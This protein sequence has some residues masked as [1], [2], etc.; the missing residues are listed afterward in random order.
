M[1][2]EKLLQREFDEKID[3]GEITKEVIGS[4]IKT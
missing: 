1:T 2:F 3:L 4:G